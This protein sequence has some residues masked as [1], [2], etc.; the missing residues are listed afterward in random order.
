M[1]SI[2]IPVYNIVVTELIQ[3]ITEQAQKLGILYEINVYDDGSVSEVKSENK[4]ISDIQNVRYVELEINLGRAAIRNKMGLESKFEHLL[5]IDADSLL[6][7]DNYLECFIQNIKLNRILCGGTTYSAQKPKESEKLL[8]WF[9][10]QKREAVTAEIRN[11]QKG[12]IITSNNFLIEKQV[13]E[14]NH[15]RENLSDYG[16]EDTLLGYD[17]FKNDFEIFHI[18]NPVKHTGLE[19]SQLFLDKTKTAVK[20]LEFIAEEILGGEND[21][22]NQVNLLNRYFRIVR[23]IP[24]AVLAW[25]FRLCKKSMERNLTGS[26]PRLF[27]FDLFKLGYLASLKNR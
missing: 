27:L 5:F 7:K 17:L 22:I 18:D 16:H 12:F 24:K 11:A 6:I 19:D 25:F 13:F 1:L 10:G 3:Q 23:F 26:N 14:K 9:Y 4:I 20:N 21:F 8:R 15:F 2:N